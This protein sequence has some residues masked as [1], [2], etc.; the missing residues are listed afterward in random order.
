[1]MKVTMIMRITINQ[2]MKSTNQEDHLLLSYM[3][4]EKIAH[5]SVVYLCYL[6]MYLCGFEALSVRMS[7]AGANKDEGTNLS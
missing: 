4:F 6:C 3:Y 7:G 5:M 1:M 2:K